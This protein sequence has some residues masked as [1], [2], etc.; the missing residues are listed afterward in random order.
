M[1]VLD[2]SLILNL[3]PNHDIFIGGFD[4]NKKNV[5]KIKSKKITATIG[6]HA[7][8]GAKALVKIFDHYHGYFD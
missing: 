2:A 7:F 1:G 5:A 3:K 6:G 4:W 8:A